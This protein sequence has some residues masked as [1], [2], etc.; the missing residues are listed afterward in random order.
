[1][2]N[3]IHIYDLNIQKLIKVKESGLKKMLEK[4]QNK[5]N[6]FSLDSDND[7]CYSDDEEDDEDLTINDL[8][9]KAKRHE[10]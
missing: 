7:I 8:I 10:R 4:I 2:K 5:G 9:K 3:I 1:M 6:V